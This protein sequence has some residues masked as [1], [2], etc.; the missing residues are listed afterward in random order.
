MR[1]SR[2]L[3]GYAFGALIGFVCCLVDV[4]RYCLRAVPIWPTLH[5][6]PPLKLIAVRII[7][8]LKP[9]YRES[10]ETHG[11]SLM[12]MTGRC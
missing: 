4:A 3:W 9:A 1:S 7:S 12:G 6:L 10:Y 11:L 8:R 2:Y 5:V